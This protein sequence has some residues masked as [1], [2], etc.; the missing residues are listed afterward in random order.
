MYRLSCLIVPLRASVAGV[1]PGDQL[2]G[3][4]V[5][6]GGWLHRVGAGWHITESDL[7]AA[8]GMAADPA[9]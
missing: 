5:G 6:G 2:D 3:A 8:L 9:T 1:C 7:V 4:A